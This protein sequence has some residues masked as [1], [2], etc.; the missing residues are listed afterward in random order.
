LHENG[1][2]LSLVMTK[3]A[4]VLIAILGL[5]LNP[6]RFF[7]QEPGPPRL[8]VPEKT[9]DFLSP[10]VRPDAVFMRNNLGEF[11]LVPRT[12]YEEFERFLNRDEDETPLAITTESLDE[13]EI[14][15]TIENNIARLHTI[16]KIRLSE[17]NKRWLNVPMGFGSTQVIPSYRVQEAT[18][19]F[20]PLRIS[21][22]S[23]GYYWRLS[24]SSE[25]ERVLEFDAVC[26]VA[27]TSQGQSLR[28]DLPA[29]PTRIR[30]QLSK[31]PWDLNVTG[32]GSEVVEPFRE[33]EAHSEG[34]VRTSGGPIAM[35][36]SKQLAADQIQAI[37]V[38]SKTS[39]ATTTDAGQLRAVSQL[40]IRGPKA[41]GGRLF[42]VTLPKGCQW[43]EPTTALVPFQGYRITRSDASTAD[44]TVLRVEFEE[45]VSRTEGEVS[46]EWQSKL[47]TGPQPTEFA[48]PLVEGVQRHVGSLDLSLPRGIQFRWEPQAGIEFSKQFGDASDVVGYSFRV[49]QQTQPLIATCIVSDNSTKLRGSYQAICDESSVYLSGSIEIVEDL[50]ALPFLQ[51]ELSDWNIEQIQVFP[52]GRLLDISAERKQEAAASDGSSKN[53]KSIPLSLSDLDIL[54]ASSG[55]GNMPAAGDASAP[56]VNEPNSTNDSL[57]N[58]T[59]RRIT[60]LLSMPIASGDPS[61]PHPI[62]FALPMLSWIDRE[63]QKRIAVSAA[64]EVHIASYDSKLTP[65]EELSSLLWTPT[66]DRSVSTQP[67]AREREATSWRSQLKYRVQPANQWPIWLGSAIVSNATIQANLDSSLT[68]AGESVELIQEWS[69]TAQGRIPNSVLVAL[70]KDWGADSKPAVEGVRI[71]LDNQPLTLSEEIASTAELV[72]RSRMTPEVAARYSWWTLPIAKNGRRALLPSTSRS[73]TLRKRW[74]LSDQPENGIPFDWVLPLVTA[75]S[76]D[77]EFVVERYAGEIRMEPLVHCDLQRPTPAQASLNS[78][79]AESTVPFD[80]TLQDPRL[81]GSLRPSRP[82]TTDSIVVESAWLQT[83]QNAVEQRERF[84][85]R[86]S[87]YAKSISLLLPADQVADCRILLNGKKAIATPNPSRIGRIDIPLGDPLAEE[88]SHAETNYVLEVFT[89]PSLEKSW[90]KQLNAEVPQILNCRQ[91]FPLVWQII[92]PVTDHLVGTSLSLSP[93]YRWRWKDLWLERQSEWTQDRLE[94]QMGASEQPMIAQQTNQYI[95][96]ALDQGTAMQVWFAPRYLLWVPVALFML[97]MLY[98]VVEF[99]WMQKPWLAVV[100]LIASVTFSQ[101]AWDLSIAFAQSLMAA[102]GIATIYLALK[103]VLDRRSRRRSVFVTHSKVAPPSLS[104]KQ[105]ASGSSI[106]MAKPPAAAAPIAVAPPDAMAIANA[107]NVVVPETPSTATLGHS[108]EAR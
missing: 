11:I 34:L 8:T 103:W 94:R 91:H 5:S 6:G 23:A 83:M 96:Y 24:P 51:L 62:R 89:W 21:N 14:N 79:V 28:L 73:L 98:S 4:C 107:K 99:R 22:D 80:C 106:G 66:I 78:D 39:Y 108:G 2:W 40:A 82:S 20:P 16:A 33:T 19:T 52:S 61:R 57:R 13:L 102:I 64:G 69:L 38:E 53:L 9:P 85:V 46:I 49:V 68:I 81:V 36:W 63:S 65:S 7:A 77:D 71:T 42:L 104:G 86:F 88:E 26:N 3:A 31:G 35:T 97:V 55:S 67:V 93:G 17:P 44:E 41:L 37:E 105:M 95:L 45:S 75:S 70:P 27:S 25:T 29:A 84:V 50:R 12:K 47:Q 59:S 56:A 43:R 60:F 90:I 72:E 76:D 32:T 100:L 48:I 74:N 15:L 30:L 10:G 92:T 58:P 18:A 101:W 54:P 87:T 1:T